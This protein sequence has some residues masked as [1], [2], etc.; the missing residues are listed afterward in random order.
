MIESF[1]DV[2]EGDVLA[3]DRGPGL[4][5]AR[6]VE[7]RVVKVTA[8]QINCGPYSKF[9]R[10][11][12]WQLGGGLNPRRLARIT[13]EIRQALDDE[14]LRLWGKYGAQRDLEK[15]SLEG[16]RKVRAFVEELIKEE[17]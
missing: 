12:G 17:S 4:G 16:L 5:A 15:L 10:K 11:D 3:E 2:K 8:T 14:K 7:V 6:W 9:R 1:M 13:P